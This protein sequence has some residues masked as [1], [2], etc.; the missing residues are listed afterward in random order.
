MQPLIST[1]FAL[2]VAVGSSAAALAT[3]LDGTKAPGL[4]LYRYVAN[5]DTWV[6]QGVADTVFTAENVANI[7]TA[8]AH[9]LRTGMPVTVSN[10][11]GA[12]PAGLSA[13]TVYWANVIDVNTFYL[14]D[15]LA[16]ALAGGSTGRKDITTNGTGTQT[17]TTTAT[18]GAGSLFVPSGV[19]EWL[20]GAYGAKVSVIQDSAAGKASITPVMLAA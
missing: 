13:A 6:A 12:L 1:P 8:T 16:H 11:G 7:F 3:A 9:K 20:D 14:Y 2:E 15:T 4:A 5:T 19:V 10:A 18:A 17:M